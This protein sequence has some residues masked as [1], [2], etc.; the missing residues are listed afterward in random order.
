MMK[1]VMFLATAF[2][3]NL[4]ACQSLNRSSR[5]AAALSGPEGPGPRALHTAVWTGSGMLVWGGTTQAKSHTPP[6]QGSP[7]RVFD[8]ADTGYGWTATP[9]SKAI[10]TEDAGIYDPDDE[11][12]EQLP[13]PQPENRYYHSSNWTGS[14]LLVWGGIGGNLG[15]PVNTGFIFNPESAAPWTPISMDFAPTPRAGH[16]AAWT[17]EELVVW[18]GQ[19]GDGLWGD[20]AIYERQRDTWRVLPQLQVPS[21]RAFHGTAWTGTEMLVWGGLGEK[22]ALHDG[23]AL[24]PKT[25]DWKE[26]SSIDAPTARF[27]HLAVWTGNSFIVWGGKNDKDDF[28]NSGG[29]YDP[30]SEHWKPLPKVNA[31]SPRQLFAHVWTGTHL[32]VWG[33]HNGQKA[34]NDGAAF[35]PATNTWLTIAPQDGVEARYMHSLVWTGSELIIFGGRNGAGE[36]LPQPEN[37]RVLRFATP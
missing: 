22:G 20:G 3:A 27:G 18:G 12:W 36:L 6:P 15:E 4:L 30:K 2:L 31:P 19:T 24:D 8:P 33:G 1:P 21:P 23:Y 14:E 16:G 9:D 29:I 10:V 28:F 25:G 13:G 35:D 37:G 34:F 17:G 7:D 11:S 26:L 32:I 5:S